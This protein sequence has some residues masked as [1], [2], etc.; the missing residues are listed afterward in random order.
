MLCFNMAPQV[1]NLIQHGAA[2]SQVEQS[3]VAHETLRLL[4]Y[5]DG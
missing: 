5:V 4:L 1:T 3:H 2:P